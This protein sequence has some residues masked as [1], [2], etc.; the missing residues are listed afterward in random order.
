MAHVLMT[1]SIIVQVLVMEANLYLKP[2]YAATLAQAVL[3]KEMYAG[4]AAMTC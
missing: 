2:S 1:A 4:I 3:S